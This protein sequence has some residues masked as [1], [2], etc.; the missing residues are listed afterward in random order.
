MFWLETLLLA[1]PLLA[2]LLDRVR[3]SPQGLFAA[4]AMVVAGFLVNRLN[5]STTGLE[6]SARVRYFPSWIEISVTLTIVTLGLVLFRLAVRHLPV[7]YPMQPETAS[8]RPD[9]V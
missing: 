6:A 1:V 5:V 3:N 8:E 7:F 4:A 2:I 9:G